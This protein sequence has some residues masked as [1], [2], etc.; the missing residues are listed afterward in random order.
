MSALQ[1]RERT[2]QNQ[3]D[4]YRS[5]LAIVRGQSKY[6]GL[7]LEELKDKTLD[8]VE[9]MNK[10]EFELDRDKPSGFSSDPSD[11]RWPQRSFRSY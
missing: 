10:F 6:E 4:D 7:T 2:L 1:D 9:R 11:P 8:F 5:R 3:V